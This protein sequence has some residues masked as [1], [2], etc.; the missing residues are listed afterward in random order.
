[1]I[2]QFAII[3][4]ALL[5]SCQLTLS[6][7]VMIQRLPKVK[8]LLIDGVL[9]EKQWSQS[10][11]SDCLFSKNSEYVVN[12][13]SAVYLMYDSEFMY[14]AFDIKS[15]NC[16]IQCQKLH[17]DDE[18]ILLNEWVAF[19]LDSYNDG[20]TSYTFIVDVYGNQFDGTLNSSK[21]LSNSFS[22]DFES[23][24]FHH[25]HGYS[26]EMKIPL[27]K[28]PFRKEKE[29]T[30]GVLFVY[31]DLKS[32]NE[33]QF[34]FIPYDSKNKLDAFAKVKLLKLKKTHVNH[35][36]G[37]DV[38]QRLQYKRRYI[39]DISTLEG[40]AKG[41]D[42]SIMDYYI[43]KKSDIQ[44]HLKNISNFNYAPNLEKD[45][46][47]TFFK[48]D[49]IETNYPNA[50]HFEA[51]LDRSQTAA[52]LVLQDDTIIYER[53]FNDFN[54]DSI[55]TSF[56]MSKSIA[57]ILTG[58]AIQEGYI[59]SENDKITDYLPELSEKDQRFEQLLIKD[60]LSMS[61]GIHYNEDGFPGDDDFTYIAPNL[62]QTAI[63]RVFISKEPNTVWLYNNYNPI[64]LGM[65]LERATQKS[66]S[67]F[68]EANLWRYIGSKPASWSLDETG[69]E[70]MESGFNAV[71]RDYLNVGRLMLNGG[72]FNNQPILSKEW[73][74]KST[75]PET[76][77]TGYYEFLEQN[78]LYYQ[79]FWWGKKRQ[80]QEHDFF[81]LGNKGQYLYI[82]PSQRIVIL[83]LGIEYG[84]FTP[85]PLSWPELFYEFGSKLN[86]LK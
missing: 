68:L 48:T 29:V 44:P 9:S 23:A 79:Y 2:N 4:I 54:K 58:I 65:I 60:L 13:T 53:Y 40:R 39:T 83:R 82:I 1:M 35:L 56:S 32:G 33:F 28:L 61:S 74:H 7:Q 31:Q 27:N 3:S 77:P 55:V 43:F 22:I 17:K 42:A 45:V 81:A 59:T 80:K 20:I 63:D 84:L 51:F 6:Q 72:S 62:R 69:F 73:V 5:L 41:G 26:V 25:A 37:V 15:G 12:A 75:Q 50:T 67:E 38:S 71:A 52:F 8:T 11:I 34:P 16:N 18:G 64:L 85:A 86:D 24:V 19:S 78:N 49:F 10:K 70:K 66:V 57:S 36:S 21:D 76:K 46:A 14:V 30:M 47:E